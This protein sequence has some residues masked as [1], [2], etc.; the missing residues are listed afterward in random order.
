[1]IRA[2]GKRL[3][4]AKG[5]SPDE[6][7]AG[8]RSAR[9]GELERIVA[10]MTAIGSMILA[11][12]PS[13][14]IFDAMVRGIV[15]DSGADFVI[16]RIAKPGGDVF[17][18]KACAGLGDVPAEP[19]HSLSVSR[20]TFLDLCGGGEPLADGFL[21]EAGKACA[22]ARRPGAALR[23]I[24]GRK[25]A[26]RRHRGKRGRRGLLH[27]RILRRRSRR[28]SRLPAEAVPGPRASRSAARA[29]EGAA[30]RQ[31]ARSRDLQGGARER[32]PAQIQFPLGRLARAPHAAH[33]GQGV[34]RNAP[35]QRGHDQTRDAPGFSPRHGRGERAD[36][37]ARRQHI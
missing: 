35:R 12:A 19:R 37:Q 2:I 22:R 25:D 21:V 23:G 30:P 4:G 18:M 27:R 1:M 28:A 13:R 6:R 17:E 9:E 31:G 33:V 3:L 10:R 32:Q 26:S 14:D 11:D 8:A 29:R 20:T 5:A 24:A 15:E 34:H 16:L 7:P 36:H